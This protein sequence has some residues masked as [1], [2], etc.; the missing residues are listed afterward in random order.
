MQSIFPEWLYKKL[1]RDYLIDFIYEVRLRV[2]KPIAVHY[3]GNYENITINDNYQTKNIIATKELIDYVFTSATKHSL[4]A[5]NSEIKEGYVTTDSG[6]RI[7]LCGQ[8]VY[9]KNEVATIKNIT[10]MNIRISHQVK[11]CSARIIDFVAQ[12]GI[13]KNTLIVSPPGAGKTTMIRDIVSKLANEKNIQNIL[14]VD[15]RFEIIGCGNGIFEVG[16]GVDVVSG[17]SK[18]FAFS[19]CLKTMNPS[20]I[21]TD[22]ISSEKD[23]EEIKQATRSG[24]SVVATAHADGLNELRQK[25]FFSKLIEEKIFERFVVISKRCG[26]GTIELVADANLKGLYIPYL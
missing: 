9:D 26:A 21:V 10:S 25:R 3:K 14:V 24:V 18:D 4:Y 23:I 2:G 12:N 11:N 22:E 8:V 1:T 13:V 20:V 5:Y 19:R 15:E 6:I 16:D 7:G 17:A